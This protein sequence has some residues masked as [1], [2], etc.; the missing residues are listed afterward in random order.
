MKISKKWLKYSISL[1][2]III[3][4]ISI[5]N[6]KIDSLGIFGNSNYLLKAAKTLTE[7]QMI[8]G[9]SNY[10]HRLFEE[11]IIKNLQRKNDVI[12]IGSSKTMLL[13]KRFFLKKEKNFF[14]HSVTGASLED[15]ISIIGAYESIH[16]Y[17][18]STVILGIDPWVF[19]K[20]S[21]QKRWKALEKYYNYEMNNILNSKQKQIETINTIK[22]KQLF[23]YEYSISN[24]NHFIKTINNNDSAFYVTDTIE[25]DDYI[26]EL[27]GSNWYPYKKRYPDYDYVKRSAIA[28]T[29]RVYGLE[30]FDTL[31]NVKL[32]ENFIKYLE[33]KKIK[34]IF[35]LPPYHPIGYDILSKNDKYKNILVAEEYLNSFAYKNKIPLYGS[36]NP[37]KYKL[38]NKDFIDGNHPQDNVHEKIF[39]YHNVTV[40]H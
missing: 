20:Y 16:G 15:Y 6:Y 7:G 17:I 2:M 10:D 36:Y 31:S 8:A 18:P 3:F 33:S 38:T 26:K 11:F 29:K 24:I 34:I 19:N 22:W 35:Y 5:F 12:L 9:L 30:G 14:N 39:N 1:I 27:D 28:V 4:F 25:I 23:N 40:E 37:Y 13:R 21:K 32:F